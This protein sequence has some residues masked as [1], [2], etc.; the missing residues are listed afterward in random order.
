ML[1][2]PSQLAA[3][4]SLQRPSS[5]SGLSPSQHTGSRETVPLLEGAHGLWLTVG[6]VTMHLT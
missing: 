2:Y 3:A 6:A 1:F 5:R 4:W